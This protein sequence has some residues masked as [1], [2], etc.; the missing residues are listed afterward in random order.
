MPI[1]ALGVVGLLAAG[2]FIDKTGEGISDAGDGVAKIGVT[3][4]ILFLGAKYF[5]VL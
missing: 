1:L 5:K 2:Y 3:A 4:G